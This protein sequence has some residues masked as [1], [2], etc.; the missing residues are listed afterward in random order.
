MNHPSPSRSRVLALTLAVLF[1][2]VGISG[3]GG[4]DEESSSA[5][6]NGVDRAFV[7]E[8]IPHHESAL[9]M[10]KIAQQRSQRPQIKELAQNI[11]DSQTKELATLTSAQAALAKEGVAKGDLGVPAHQMGM[12]MDNAALK[13]ADPFDRA[14]IDMMVPH[15]QGAVRM[16]RVELAK[17]SDPELK[18]LAQEIIAEQAREIGEMNQW[19]TTYYGAASPAG[20]VPAEGAAAAP[21]AATP[22]PGAGGEHGGGHSG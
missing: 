7:E 13:T 14:F 8:M 3:C 20:G 5:G 15:H 10:A 2:L 18:K 11:I 4:D 12:D 19:R 22:A 1:A 16:A 6:G 17:G 9:E 21:G